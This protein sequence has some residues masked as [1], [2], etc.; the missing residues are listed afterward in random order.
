MTARSA[1]VHE[2]EKAWA[3]SSGML[4]AVGTLLQALH[5]YS[6]SISLSQSLFCPAPRKSFQRGGELFS[7][8]NELNLQ[9][10][11]LFVRC[12][13]HLLYLFI[14]RSSRWC[15]IVQFGRLKVFS[16]F[17]GV[18]C[19]AVQ[20][21]L[22]EYLAFGSWGLTVT[23]T[24]VV[25]ITWWW[26]CFIESRLTQVHTQ[27]IIMLRNNDKIKFDQPAEARGKID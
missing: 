2:Q 22:V 21:N 24:I 6:E 16:V 20:C 13:P 1:L 26:C 4:A 27:R 14:F 19:N 25:L 18:Q 10:S 9:S 3:S 7:S 15:F 23:G 11:T 12:G 8:T 5:L 17:F